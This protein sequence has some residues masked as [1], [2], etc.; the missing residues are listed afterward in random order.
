MN[1]L[2]RL[3]GFL[4]PYLRRMIL[5]AVLLAVSGVLMAL[6]VST[7]KPIVN[8]VLMPSIGAAAPSGSAASRPDILS[9]TRSFLPI[10]DLGDW[11]RNNHVM[12]PLILVHLLIIFYA[13]RTGISA[14]NI[15][16]RTQGNI[17][18]AVYYGAFVVLASV[19]GAI[20]VRTV[21]REWTRLRGALMIGYS[22][23]SA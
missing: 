16:S 5:A 22:E 15:L 12:V 9:I 20:G 18:W 23:A 17:G 6:A 21:L 4:R 13:T 3:G 2:W 14:E 10:D 8:E 19:H 1:E 11:S 7:T